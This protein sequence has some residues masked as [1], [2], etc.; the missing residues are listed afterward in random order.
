MMS[1][2]T[3]AVGAERPPVYVGLMSGTSLDGISAVT[4][5]FHVRD[6]GFDPELLAFVVEPYSANRRSRLEHAMQRGT[7]QEYCRLAFDLGEWLA[8]AAI[9]VMAE[10]GV[11]RGEVRA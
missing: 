3:E 9:A 11:P 2:P 5:R 7:A 1:A 10:S 6:A 4:V 8:A